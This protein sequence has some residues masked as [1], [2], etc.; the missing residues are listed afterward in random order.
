MSEL[1]A[2][3]LENSRIELDNF[4]AKIRYNH[5]EIINK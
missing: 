2:K 5:I 1:K 3:I 4:A